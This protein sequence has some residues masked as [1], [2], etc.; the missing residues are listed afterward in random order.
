VGGARVEAAHGGDADIVT[1][2]DSA[3]NFR[4]AGL[5]AQEYVIRT[6]KDGYN[7]RNRDV[8]MVADA[9]VDIAMAR[10]RVAVIGSV[11]EVACT[12]TIDGV[13]VEVID[14][15][16]AGKSGI[17]GSSRY[18][19]SDVSWGSFRVRASRVGYSPA[20]MSLNVPP[21]FPISGATV[22]ADF[23]LP[24][25]VP[26]FSV[27]GDLRNRMVERGGS[28]NGALVE[29]TGG[30]NVGRS[31][32]SANGAYRFENLISGPT[33]L[34]ISHPDYLTEVLEGPRVCDGDMRYDVRLTPTDATLNGIVSDAR[35]GGP[36]SGASVEILNGPPAGKSA[37]TDAS[38]AYAIVGISGTFTE[39]V[40]KAGYVT[41]ER[42]MTT[43][44]FQ[45]G[46]FQLTPN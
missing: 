7:V 24:S 31:T 23:Q 44:A 13:R 17:S 19:I 8:L 28:V 10:N 12:T 21:P 39:R 5:S 42:T 25:L 36:V 15:P 34:R 2:A 27:T 18:E 33:P 29:I 30:Q 6:F 45:A 26:R 4:L 1:T 3:G 35:T 11:T 37:T 40:S 14:G 32:T 16:D 43:G 22:R 9:R 38:G 20:E 41:Q 46:N